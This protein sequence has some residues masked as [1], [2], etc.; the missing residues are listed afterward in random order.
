MAAAIAAA[1]GGPILVA[2]SGG[3][4]STA[5]LAMLCERLGP[6]AL[7]A[8]IV[9]HALRPEAA[10]EASAAARSAA[11]LGVSSEIIS[12]NW[13][14]GTRPAQ[15]A[16]RRARLDALCVCARRLGARVIALGHTAD[17]QAETVW[18]RAERGSDWRGLAAMRALAPAPVWPQG[19]GMHFLRPLLGVRRA[20]LRDWLVARQANWVEDPSNQNSAYARVRARAALAQLEEVGFD[21]LRLTAMA[22]RLRPLADRLDAEARALIAAGARFEAGEASFGWNSAC[23]G[24]AGARAVAA[25][26]AAAAG[27][28]APPPRAAVEQAL[29]RLKQ[30]PGAASLGGA[31]LRRARIEGEDR[32]SFTR[33]AGAVQGRADGPAPLPPLDLPAE[34]PTVW[35]GRIEFVAASPGWRVLRDPAGGPAPVLERGGA[36]LPLGAT[37]DSG[38]IAVRWL[39]RDHVAQLLG[40]AKIAA[41]FTPP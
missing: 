39:L 37:A 8:A 25:L 32:L 13:P 7:H 27:A 24:E 3:G 33:D 9:D 10:D 29:T 20:A 36:S 21:P 18:L 41:S 34:E 12:L 14:P 17:D 6:R 5:L 40:G 11:A 16:A 28:P 15:A 19:R 30:E 22:A 1:Q 38:E 23:A 35:D 26:I 4:D 2:L 31:L